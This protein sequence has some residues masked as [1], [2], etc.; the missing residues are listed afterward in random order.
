MGGG[1]S[2]DIWVACHR[3]NPSKGLGKLM[4]CGPKKTFLGSTEFRRG[5][6]GNGGGASTSTTLG[7]MS[8]YQPVKRFRQPH[9]MRPKK[10]NILGILWRSF[11]EHILGRM[12]STKPVKWFRQPHAMRPQK[13]FL[14]NTVEDSR[15]L[16]EELQ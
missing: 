4:A 5:F 12:S 16:V 14:G 15:E 6:K 1:A 13:T 10:K 2:I 3:M 11:N 7:R 8:S 9:G